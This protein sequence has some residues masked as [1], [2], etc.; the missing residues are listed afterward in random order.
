MQR[1]AESPDMAWGSSVVFNLCCALLEA[2]GST[3]EVILCE[4]EKPHPPTINI[5]NVPKEK[6]Y[7][8]ICH[9]LPA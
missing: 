3:T 6:Y 5:K 1:T 4:N 8:D 2:Q 9:N 7:R